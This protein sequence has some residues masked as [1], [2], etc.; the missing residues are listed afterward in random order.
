[1]FH[2]LLGTLR[3]I[4]D[5]ILLVTEWLF[6][7]NS[8]LTRRTLCLGMKA[9]G[10]THI[11]FFF[12]FEFAEMTQGHTHAIK[13]ASPLLLLQC[14]T[15]QKK[16]KEGPFVSFMSFVHLKISLKYCKRE[17]KWKTLTLESFMFT[18]LFTCTYL[19][20][21]HLLIRQIEDMS[22]S[23]CL[24]WGCVFLHCCLISFPPLLD[25]R[26]FDSDSSNDNPYLPPLICFIFVFP[27]VW[28]TRHYHKAQYP[29]QLAD[30]R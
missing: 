21:A 1:M 13:H 24:C 22:L 23:L 16:M 12:P 15:V 20:K 18:D 2:I 10:S 4:N 11:Y 19:L 17:F 3:N 9:D 30:A 25:F 8:P 26:T 28:V 7:P 14:L 5:Q 29:A 27:P 6:S